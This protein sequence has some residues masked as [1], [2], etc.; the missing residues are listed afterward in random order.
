MS[1][2]LN[3]PLLRADACHKCSLNFSCAY[4]WPMHVIVRSKTEICHCRLTP[5]PPHGPSTETQKERN[6]PSF[7]RKVW[8]EHAHGG[9]TPSALDGVRSLRARIWRVHIALGHADQVRIPRSA[10]VEDHRQPLLEGG[11]APCELQLRGVR[12]WPGSVQSLKEMG[13]GKFLFVTLHSPSALL[14]L[15]QLGGRKTS[16]IVS[17]LRLAY[18]ISVVK[19]ARSIS[20]R[21]CC[22]RVSAVVKIAQPC[23]TYSWT[24][25]QHIII[26]K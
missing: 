16:L 18:V 23:V 24:T 22:A 5:T 6:S 10:G 25:G 17:L 15:F 12:G 14:L 7:S 2:K 9:R 19:L 3:A 13:G 20:R 4:T 26:L 11:M 1:S 21:V 8:S